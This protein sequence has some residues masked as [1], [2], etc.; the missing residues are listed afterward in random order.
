[1]AKCKFESASVTETEGIHKPL[2]LDD[3]TVRMHACVGLG[4]C[5]CA[6][7]GSGVGACAGAGLGAGTYACMLTCVEKRVEKGLRRGRVADY[8]GRAHDAD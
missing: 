5:V 7:L 6:C 4:A 3:I 2:S 1:M 8:A